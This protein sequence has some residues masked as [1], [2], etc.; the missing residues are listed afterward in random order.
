MTAERL[1]RRSNSEG[2]RPSNHSS[3][4]RPIPAAAVLRPTRA[5]A[6][7][8]RKPTRIELKPDDIE[9]FDQYMKEK[10]AMAAREK[11][12]GGASAGEARPLAPKPP[13]VAE[14]IGLN[15]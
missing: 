15:K 8:R 4:S 12:A 11:G 10:A 9:E 2:N 3:K 1:Q 6:M 7:L 5:R 14:R 13:T